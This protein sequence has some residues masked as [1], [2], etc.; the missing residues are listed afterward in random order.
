M[1]VVNNNY[2]SYY[3]NTNIYVGTTYTVGYSSNLII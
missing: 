2:I 3:I 1:Y